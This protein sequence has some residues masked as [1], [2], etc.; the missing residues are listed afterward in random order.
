VY[1]KKNVPVIFYG[2]ELFSINVA[3]GSYSPE[4]RASIILNRLK[5]VSEDKSF[6]AEEIKAEIKDGYPCITYKDIYIM[7]LN[8]EDGKLEGLSD[9]EAADKY[10]ENIRNTLKT[11]KEEHSF[12]TIIYGVI[13]SLLSTLIFILFLTM[14]E[15]ILKSIHKKINSWHGNRISDI[16]IQ[17]LVLISGDRI[18]GVLIKLLA[19][20]GFI[21]KFIISYVYLSFV[22]SFFVWTRDFGTRLLSYILSG[23]YI[24]VGNFLSY[25]PHIFFILFVTVITYYIIKFVRFVFEELDKGTVEFPGFYREWAMPT[26]MIVRFLIIALSLIIIFPYLPGYDS[27]AFKGISLFLGVLLSLGSTAVVSN[28]LAGIILIYMSAFKIGDRV[29][30]GDVTGDIIE[31]TLLITRIRTTKNV[32]ITMPNAMILGSYITNYSS[33]SQKPGLILHTT[34]T[35]GYDVPWKDVHKLLIDAALAT[36]DI[37]KEPPPFILQTSLDDFYVSYQLNAYTNKSNSMARIYSEIHQN[38]Q[39]KFNE[40][41]VEIMSPH[42]RSMR[43][44]NQTTIPAGYLPENYSPPPFKFSQEE[45]PS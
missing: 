37:L 36:G 6:N 35:I 40:G 32:D 28:I 31:K 12:K 17:T 13:Y 27:P 38:I 10:A 44:G 3:M 4:E 45:K 1:D 21:L 14:V 34:V 22:F 42:Y 43:D 41:G 20:A 29:K 23:L 15:R 25:I 7:T 9:R 30:I 33:A 24:I 39:D 5:K 18:A 11:Y 8:R 2:K 19:S 26:Y 16:K